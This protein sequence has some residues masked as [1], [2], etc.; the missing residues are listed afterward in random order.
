MGF[1]LQGFAPR[2]Q[3]YVVSDAGTLLWL[4][5]SSLRKRPEMQSHRKAG[6]STNGMCNPN[7]QAPPTSGFCSVRESATEDERFRLEPVRSPP[8]SFPLQGFPPCLDGMAFTMPPLMRLVEV[9]VSVHL[10]T[11]LQGVAPDKVG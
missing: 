8:G 5:T 7:P 4:R 10:R 1:T 11:P 6:A 3:L 9:N 2:A